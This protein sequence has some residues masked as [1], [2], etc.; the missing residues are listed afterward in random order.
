[1]QE[2]EFQVLPIHAAKA[3]KALEVELQPVRR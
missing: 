2:Y 1:M 3:Q